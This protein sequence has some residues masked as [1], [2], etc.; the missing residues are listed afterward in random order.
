MSIVLQKDDIENALRASGMNLEDALEFLNA[1]RAGSTVNNMDGW[2]RPDIDA[3]PF[4]HTTN[5]AYSSHRF[6]PQQQL[7]F[8]IPPVSRSHPFFLDR[9]LNYFWVTITICGNIL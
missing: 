2:R 9:V 6:N 4:D 5:Q 1:T 3:S 8:A 7:P